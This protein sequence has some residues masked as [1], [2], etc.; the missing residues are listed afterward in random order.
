MKNFIKESL[1]KIL[2]E[3]LTD[4][5]VDVDAIYDKYFKNGVDEIARTNRLTKNI[6]SKHEIKTSSLV[7]EDAVKANE[8][9]PCDIFINYGSN[10]YRPSDSLISIGYSKGAFDFIMDNGNGD[11]G[12]ALTYLDDKNQKLSLIKEFTEERIKGSIHHELVHWI[13]DTL[14]NRHITKRIGKALQQKTR[15]INGIPVNATKMEIQ[16]QIHNIKQLYNKYKDSWNKITFDQMLDLSPSLKF[17]YK[18]LPSQFKNEWRRNIK[19]R[20][21]REG[22]LGKNMVGY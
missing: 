5:E 7:S 19:R 11:I 6:F 13:D 4:V 16:A 14:H 20:M 1:R 21:A 12:E 9:N 22:L 15:D 3:K 2:N 8:L 18:N 10:F 17:I